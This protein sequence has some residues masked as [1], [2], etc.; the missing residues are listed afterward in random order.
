[1][2]QGA[3]C[4]Y[5]EGNAGCVRVY[6]YRCGVYLSDNEIRTMQVAAVFLLCS[7]RSLPSSPRFFFK[8]LLRR[9]SLLTPLQS[10]RAFF[11]L[12]SSSS[13]PSSSNLSLRKSSSSAPSTGAFFKR[14]LL[15]LESSFVLS[16]RLKYPR[17]HLP[18]FKSLPA[19]CH[20]RRRISSLIM[21]FLCSFPVSCVRGLV[22]WV[23]FLYLLS[24]PPS[25]LT[26]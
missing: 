21:Y 7:S 22:L 26:G 19:A 23:A 20:P 4:A 2:I 1:M 3:V 10:S 8:I 15:I 24:F 5:G 25:S 14:L 17:R 12:L 16:R 6:A 18:S 9:S 13:A 11:R